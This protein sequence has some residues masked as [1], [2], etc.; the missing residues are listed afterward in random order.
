ML[1]ARTLGGMVEMIEEGECYSSV[2][3]GNGGN[4]R[5]GRMLF[6]RTLEGWWR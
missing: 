5:G 6:A 3:W 1:F 4:D 2:H